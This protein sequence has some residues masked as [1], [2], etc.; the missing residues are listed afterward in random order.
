[1]RALLIACVLV[2]CGGK[3]GGGGGTAPGEV[4]SV[5]PA[6]RFVPAQPTYLVSA[7]TFREGQAAFT[8]FLDMAGM[9]L[10]F[11]LSEA[12][13]ELSQILGVDP[14]SPDAVAAIGVDLDG[15]MALF[16]DDLNPTFVLHLDSADSMNSF[17]EGQRQRGLRTQS[18]ISD[19][20]EVYS[21]KVGGGLHIGWA[22]EKDWLWVHF[23]IDGADGV[24]WFESSHQPDGAGWVDNWKWAA[25]KASAV[26]GVLD[27]QSLFAKIGR[28]EREA[29][30]CGKQFLAVKRVGMSVD[31]EPTKFGAALSIDLGGD[32]ERLRAQTLA[33]PVGWS[34]A[35]TNAPLAAQWN[36]DLP[37]A[38][39]WLEVCT[40]DD[41]FRV[42][43]GELGIRSFRAFLFHL[44]IDDKEAK[45]AVAAD[46]SSA[47]YMRE[48]LDQIP[49]R[50]MAESN[51]TFG[52]YKGKHV[53]V[54]F[55]AK[56]D[57]VLTDSL[58]IAAMGDGVMQTIGSGNGSPP[59]ILAIDLRPQG[60]PAGTWQTIFG[61]LDADDPTRLAQ[62][63][64]LW[65]ELHLGAQLMGSSLVIDA[66]G[67]RR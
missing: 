49:G 32:A 6:A 39:E 4:A 52:A 14:L 37:S 65:Q 29:L 60:M 23:A 27:L 35:S 13:R 3:T 19:G 50:S 51:K 16:S 47:R 44:D 30:A 36:V 33:A 24:G 7:R 31:I 66:R 20:V 61:L 2:G 53:S 46:L 55:F 15:S 12:S 25:Q 17:L 1:V 28:R 21:A 26:A 34:A 5:F 45:G 67:I 22:V 10:G 41:D 56:G 9:T 58:A 48:L 43:I 18:V 8:Q 38:T 11:E 40:G 59:P 54:P 62:R 64:L 42:A 57:Y 63:L